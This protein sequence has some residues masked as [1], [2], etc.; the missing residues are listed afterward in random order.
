VALIDAAKNNMP[1]TAQTLNMLS[2]DM[3]LPVVVGRC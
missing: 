2:S 3:W 1:G